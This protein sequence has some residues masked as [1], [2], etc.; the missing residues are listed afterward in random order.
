M[1]EKWIFRN[2]IS[3]WTKKHIP[4]TVVSWKGFKLKVIDPSHPLPQGER[5]HPKGSK[6]PWIEIFYPGV[7][8]VVEVKQ[9]RNSNR[10]KFSNENLWKLD[11]I[12][13]LASATSKMTSWPQQP[14]KRLSE[15]LK[16]VHQAEE[17]ELL[18]G[19]LFRLLQIPVLTL[20]P[21]RPP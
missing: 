2:N 10:R 3:F 9:P 4:F 18:L 1:Q 21:T 6:L 8:E 19:F 17:N 16:S 7:S 13:N 5:V 20:C 14:R 11:E 12:Q 15:F